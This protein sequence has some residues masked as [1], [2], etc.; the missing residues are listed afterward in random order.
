MDS[1]DDDLGMLVQWWRHRRDKR[2]R[3]HR[4]KEPKMQEGVDVDFSKSHEQFQKRFRLSQ[5]LHDDIHTGLR[6]RSKRALWKTCFAGCAYFL[7]ISSSPA[8][9]YPRVRSAGL[10]PY[11]T[12]IGTSVDTMT[13]VADASVLLFYIPA[14]IVIAYSSYLL[15]YYTHNECYH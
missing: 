11:Y 10:V 1:D 3:R 12:D 9:L 2:R 6:P 14:E 15:L 7:I 13:S 8:H 4:Q 5:A